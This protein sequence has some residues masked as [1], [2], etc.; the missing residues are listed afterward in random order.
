[1]VVRVAVEID[2]KPSLTA[3]FLRLR[4]KVGKGWL[5]DARLQ[6]ETISFIGDE[7]GYH[8]SEYLQDDNRTYELNPILERARLKFVPFMKTTKTLR[9][10][11]NFFIEH[12]VTMAERRRDTFVRN[13]RRNSM[14]R[15][16]RVN[17]N[18]RL[19]FTATDIDALI[20]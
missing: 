11:F 15:G 6:C 2:P 8:L 3:A 17:R 7:C 19:F 1:M 13:T 9:R 18:N 4:N 12:R 20:W 14:A 16:N 5:N 10:W